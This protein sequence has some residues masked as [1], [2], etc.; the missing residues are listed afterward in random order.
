MTQE[1]TRKRVP[2]GTTRKGGAARHRLLW[3]VCISLAVIFVVGIAAAGF[4]LHTFNGNDTWVYIPHGS[5][6]KALADSLRSRLGSAESNRVMTFYVLLGGNPEVSAG[7]YRI[8]KG[9]RSLTTARRLAKGMQTPVRVSWTN[10]R[11]LEQLADR[12]SSQLDI[13]P[14]EFL[15]ACRERLPARG[16]D[17][18]QFIA[19]FLPDSYEFYWTTDASGVVDRMADY[20]DRFW[21]DE[22]RAKAKK[23][24]LTPVE[25]S[26][27]ASI[28]EEESAKGDEYSAIARLYINRLK[29]G[30]R[31]QADPTVK[32]ATGDFSLRR[33]TGE[34]LRTHSPYNTYLHDGLPPGPIRT[35]GKNTID[36]VL[37]APSHT[38]LYMCAKE[39]FSGYHNFASDYA[40]HLSNARRYQSELNRRGIK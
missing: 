6:E 34:H 25:V 39:D 1:K 5:S 40:T 7:A 38:Y 31:L 30:M 29:K 33:I 26:T 22:R 27:I 8:E 3:M 24:G 11:T 9:Q 32:Y 4:A 37:D 17:S 28:V 2:R 14:G 36:R 23:L 12:I 18:A 16:Y 21:T 19:A 20:R 13:T 35:P 15:Q 10:A